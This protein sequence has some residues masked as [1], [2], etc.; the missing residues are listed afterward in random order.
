MSIIP[1]LGVL[2]F[3]PFYQVLRV[4]K[5]ISAQVEWL[6]KLHGSYWDSETTNPVQFKACIGCGHLLMLLSLCDLFL[7]GFN[8]RVQHMSCNVIAQLNNSFM[9]HQSRKLN[10]PVLFINALSSSLHSL[11]VSWLTVGCGVLQCFGILWSICKTH[12]F[13]KWAGNPNAD[14]CGHVIGIFAKYSPSVLTLLISWHCL[15]SYAPCAS[16]TSSEKPV[17]RLELIVNSYAQLPCWRVSEMCMF[18][19]IAF[20]SWWNAFENLRWQGMSKMS[21]G[22][23][24]LKLIAAAVVKCKW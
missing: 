21:L 4:R 8:S 24:I 7:W 10:A 6:E 20:Q 15:L 5:P 3:R 12:A 13:Y 1:K 16:R 17:C 19:A 22:T 23:T 2:L 9:L 18:Q 14:W 11:C